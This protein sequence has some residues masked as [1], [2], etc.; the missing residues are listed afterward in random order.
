MGITNAILK[1]K[2]HRKSAKT[3]EVNFLIDTKTIY[4]V[5]LILFGLASLTWVLPEFGYGGSHFPLVPVIRIILS[6]IVIIKSK[7]LAL[8]SESQ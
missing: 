3:A 5:A 7:S 1:V 2:E 6:I 4:E 8:L